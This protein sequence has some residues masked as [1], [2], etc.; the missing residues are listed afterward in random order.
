MHVTARSH[1]SHVVAPDAIAA[2]WMFHAANRDTFFRK[3]LWWLHKYI[4]KC[5]PLLKA[6]LSS[7][8][9]Y[10]NLYHICHA[11]LPYINHT[12]RTHIFNSCIY[13]YAQQIS[14]KAC[15]LLRHS[16]D[17]LQAPHEGNS[18]S[19]VLRRVDWPS[20]SWPSDK[21]QLPG[22]KQSNQA[23]RIHRLPPPKTWG[24]IESISDVKLENEIWPNK[25]SAVLCL[26]KNDGTYAH[27]LTKSH[28]SHLLSISSIGIWE[29]NI[30]GEQWRTSRA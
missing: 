9:T 20:P 2:R 1:A 25:C 17:A 6:N 8:Y 3:Y 14:T 5:L 7:I 23:W 22:C 13:I 30:P 16:I 10:I 18:V 27:V 11:S 19:P 4:K 24:W 15:V 21:H 26:S 29:K 28:M 12:I